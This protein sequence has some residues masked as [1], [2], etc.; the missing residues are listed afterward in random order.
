MRLSDQVAEKLLSLIQAE[1][2]AP[3]GRLPAERHLAGRLGVSRTALREAIHQLSSHGILVSKV[4][5][6][7]FLQTTG[8]V[9]PSPS[10]PFIGAGHLSDPQTRYDVLE[11]RQ[12]L[13]AKAAV[14]ASQRAT[15]QD[16]NKIRHCF[17]QML[18]YQTQGDV[19]LSAHADAQFHLAIVEAAHNPVLFSVVRGLFDLL[20]STV[21]QNRRLISQHDLHAAEAVMTRQHEALMCAIFD[22][23]PERAR[24]CLETHLTYVQRHLRQP[25]LGAPLRPSLEI[26]S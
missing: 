20:L 17:E 25:D 4:G 14:L 22:A 12:A 3:G 18:H 23:E 26:P 10:L 19:A 8:Q 7:T 5:A 21:A 6:G 9:S 13:E 15:E 16:K 2:I 1:G 11:T 24:H